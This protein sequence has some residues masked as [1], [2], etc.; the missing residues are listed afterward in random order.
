MPVQ[1]LLLYVARV[2]GKDS[3]ALLVRATDSGA[4]IP[5]ADLLP[6]EQPD[7]AFKRVLPELTGIKDALRLR[8]RLGKT[9]L[10]LGS[11]PDGKGPPETH[12]FH[13]LLLDAGK[14]SQE[15]WK[16]EVPGSGIIEWAWLSVEGDLASRLAPR[17][18]LFAPA[19]LAAL[20]VDDD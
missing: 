14:K 6:G 1:R 18:R 2:E 5:A 13:A 20:D 19:V 3:P 11:G 10:S 9:M 8:K 15:S 7:A 12:V 17:S 4:E 16:H